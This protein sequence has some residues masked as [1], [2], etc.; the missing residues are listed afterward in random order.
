VTRGRALAAA[1]AVYLVA[2]VVVIA[3]TS[4]GD[5]RPD[6]ADQ[7]ATTPVQPAPTVPTPA[8][9][10]GDAAPLPPVDRTAPV[11][12]LPRVP[13][14]LDPPAPELPV[15]A[16]PAT[17]VLAPLGK[18]CSAPREGAPID[19]I[20]VHVTE[21]NDRPG[22]TDLSK[23]ARFLAGRGLAAHAANDAEGNSS[24]MVADDRLAYHA[25]YWNRATVGIEQVAYADVPRDRWLRERRPQLDST[26]AWIAYWAREYRIPI[27]RCVVTGLRYNRRKRVIAGTIVK[28][29]VCSHAELDPRNRDDPGPGYPWGYV[30]AKARQIASRA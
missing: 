21:S 25:T 8:P 20:V 29:G 14:S 22:T 27:R 2:V 24:R 15:P 6:A 16:A 17:S 12:T 7:P 26:A 4:G 9:P 28:R 13:A 10:R 1:A 5:A 19:A 18:C 30:L 3:T 23:L 11:K